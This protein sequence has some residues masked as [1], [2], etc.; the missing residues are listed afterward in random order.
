[1]VIQNSEVVDFPKRIL[2]LFQN[3]SRT[4]KGVS[5]QGL[6]RFLLGSSGLLLL[7]AVL[8]AFL[9]TSTRNAKKIPRNG[10]T[11]RQE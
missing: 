11:K 5:R 9:S 7:L 3:A 4:Y 6:S 8:S 10:F 1:M 2:A